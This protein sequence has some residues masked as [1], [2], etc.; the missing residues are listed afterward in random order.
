MKPVYAEDVLRV[1]A[2]TRLCLKNPCNVLSESGTRVG[3]GSDP[4]S[5]EG[6]CD[7]TN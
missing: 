1:L 4:V 2:W 6:A 7:D 5:E 3:D